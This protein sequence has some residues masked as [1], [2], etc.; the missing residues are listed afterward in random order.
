MTVIATRENG[1][2]LLEMNDGGNPF[3][4][5]SLKYL[6]TWIDQA[7]HDMLV[8]SIILTSATK[9]FSVGG[10]LSQMLEGVEEG[11]P[12]K[13]VEEIVP[14]I[15]EIILA[16]AKSRLPI[17][18]ALNG[19]AAGGGMSLFLIGDYR[20][21]STK[22][23][24]YTAFGDL[25][26]TPDSG[27]SILLPYRM[28]G[29]GTHELVQSTFIN[30]EELV[31]RGGANEVCEP[32]DLLPRAKEIAKSY[33]SLDRWAVGQSKRFANRILLERL[34][35]YLDEEFKSIVEACRRDPFE[36]RLREVISKLSK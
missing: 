26:L 28:H 5:E 10:H 36:R 2:L 18:T 9:V 6:K 14:I 33:V 35:K 29:V 31:K 23:K 12:S 8:H 11:N 34:E 19:T 16:L 7:E 20:L 30:S 17:I 4:A 32:D 1:Y 3:T 22:G 15:N 25:A 13:Y 24:L 27:S 21:T